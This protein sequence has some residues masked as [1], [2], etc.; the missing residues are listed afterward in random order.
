MRKRLVDYWPSS[1]VGRKVV[2][3]LIMCRVPVEHQYSQ[4][5]DRYLNVSDIVHRDEV[6]LC[7]RSR[8]G[9]YMGI[10]GP[11]RQA[12]RAIRRGHNTNRIM[13]SA[14]TVFFQWVVES[15]L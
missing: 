2:A 4:E 6:G 10:A 7:E 13:T 11:H 15:V 3:P 1:N 12:F 14:M 5:E 8:W 9:A